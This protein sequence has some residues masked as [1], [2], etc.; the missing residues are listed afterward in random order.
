MR[1]MNRSLFCVLC[2]G[3]FASQSVIWAAC[4]GQAEHLTLT[5]RVFME[6][7]DARRILIA[8]ATLTDGSAE[9]VFMYT[10]RVP[11][12]IGP[13]FRNWP[14]RIDYEAG[15]GL[16]LTPDDKRIQAFVFAVTGDFAREVSDTFPDR[17][18]QTTGLSHYLANPPLRIE[19]LKALHITGDCNRYPES[20]VEVGGQRL[21]FPG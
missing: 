17:F 4:A 6:P 20:C 11:L 9:H 16:R 18:D 19:D 13:R 7:I 12:R 10:A 8:V 14:A 3:V 15:H 21:P 1:K 5:G 2:S